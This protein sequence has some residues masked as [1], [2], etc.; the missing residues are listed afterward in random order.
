[1]F[2]HVGLASLFVPEADVE[3]VAGELGALEASGSVV[4]VEL[5]CR[6]LG[7]SA[8]LLNHLPSAEQGSLEAEKARFVSDLKRSACMTLADEPEP[9]HI[10]V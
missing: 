3:P 4:L 6:L 2:C 10:E 5:L 7:R 8:E 1:M 9:L